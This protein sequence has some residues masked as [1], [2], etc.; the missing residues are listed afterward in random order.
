MQISMDEIRQAARAAEAMMAEL[1]REPE[2]WEVYDSLHDAIVRARHYVKKR[3]PE[4]V[5]V[6]V[7][8][9]FARLSE[10]DVADEV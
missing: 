2:P 10:M 9:I 8:D 7:A 1:N 4:A 5:A 6:T 3:H